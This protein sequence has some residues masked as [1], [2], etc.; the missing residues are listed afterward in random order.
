MMERIVGP[1]RVC[2]GAVELKEGVEICRDCSLV[3][4]LCICRPLKLK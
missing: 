1:C 2:G 3:I 4:A